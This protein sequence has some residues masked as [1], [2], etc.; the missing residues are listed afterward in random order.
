[1]Q[2][3][4]QGLFGL[5]ELQEDGKAVCR[6]FKEDATISFSESEFLIKENICNAQRQAQATSA[7]AP[8]MPVETAVAQPERTKT[9]EPGVGVGVMRDLTLRFNIPRGKVSQIMGIMNFLQSKFQ[10][11]E[12]E[13]R[14]RNGTL[15]EEDYSNKI[16]EALRQLGIDVENA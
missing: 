14:A 5:G 4:K 8:A 10:L 3:V 11:L 1:M 2:G 16:K 15:S 13:L 7:E 6:Y 9:A 12:M